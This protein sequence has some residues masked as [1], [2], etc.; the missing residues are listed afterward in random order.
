MAKKKMAKVEE[1]IVEETVAV[2]EQPVVKEQPKV[3]I[4]EI[5]TKSKDMWEIK[6][7]TYLLSN[8]EN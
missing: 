3:K 2:K 6:D 7:R 5:K 4:P 8:K 1:P